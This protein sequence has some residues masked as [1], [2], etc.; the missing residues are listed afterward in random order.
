MR[1]ATD[2]ER[3]L[4]FENSRR[5]IADQLGSYAGSLEI[6]SMN[7]GGVLELDGEPL[8]GDPAPTIAWAT[9]DLFFS[10]VA[11]DFMV[12]LL[13]SPGLKWLQSAS[14]GVDNPVFGQLVSRGVRLTTSHGQAVGMAD[15][16]MAGVLDHFQRGPERREAQAAHEWRRTIRIREILGTR[17]LIVGFGAVG[18]AVATRAK[19]FGAHVTGVRRNQ[20][21]DAD[22]D[23]IIP[24]DRIAEY[25]PSADVVVLACPLTAATRHMANAAFFGAMK[26]DAV[27]VNVGRGGLVDEAALLAGLD[28][29]KPARAVLDVF[30]TEPLPADSPFWSHPRVSVTAHCSGVGVGQDD[31]NRNLFLDNLDRYLAG[32]PLRNKVAPSDLTSG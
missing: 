27:L 2:I 11:R 31:R 21:T 25:L 16:V 29:G 23:Q 4:I 1:G 6:L 30:E 17:W 15:Y 32:E 3:L 10:P 18:Q 26:D 28:A 24:P 22:A 19:A 7:D 13:K 9:A 20:D 8:A 14:A 12:T 5:P